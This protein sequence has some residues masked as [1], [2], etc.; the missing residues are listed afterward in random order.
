MSEPLTDIQI[1]Q[2]RKIGELND[3]DPKLWNDVLMGKTGAERQQ[4][5]A[6]KLKAEGKKRFPIWVQQDDADALRAKFP[7]PRDGIDWQSV[8][9]AALRNDV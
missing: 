9:R 7:G 1:A 4:Q 3:G 2:I 6:D 8:I 5:L